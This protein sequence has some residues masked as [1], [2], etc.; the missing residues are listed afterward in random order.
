MIDVRTELDRVR[1]Q[2]AELESRQT[3]LTHNMLADD[4]EAGEATPDSPPGL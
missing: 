3:A 2:M 4:P 1:K